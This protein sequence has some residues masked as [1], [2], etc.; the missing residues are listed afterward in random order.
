MQLYRFLMLFL[1]PV[2]LSLLFGFDCQTAVFPSYASQRIMT[3]CSLFFLLN[4][5]PFFKKQEGLRISEIWKM[6]STSVCL[7]VAL[8]SLQMGF[9]LSDEHHLT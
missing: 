4:S 6:I 5:G 7:T 2:S 3:Y 8:H 9:K 1:L